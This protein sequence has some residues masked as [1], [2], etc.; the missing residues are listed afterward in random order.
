MATHALAP[1]ARGYRSG[2][3]EWLTTTDH[4]KIGILY[5]INSFIFFF[6]AGLLALGRARRARPARAAVRDRPDV[7]RAV[8]DA[9]HGDD[10][11][12]HHPDPGG[13]R[14]LHRAAPG[15]RAGHG[16]PADQR[17]VV[18]DAAAR[19]DPALPRLRDR[20]RGRGRLDE[21]RAVVGGPAALLGRLR[22]GP[23]DR[24]A[25]AGRHELDPRRHQL[26][27]HDL[28]DAGARG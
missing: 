24:V 7:Q 8:H 3:Y 11:P 13:L 21:L 19:R 2:L 1:A 22:A 23:V 14:E 12:V 16:L 9:R 28:Q 6:L 25:R 5:L 17:A 10:L 18:L 27:R 26:P 20:W 15:R 4:K